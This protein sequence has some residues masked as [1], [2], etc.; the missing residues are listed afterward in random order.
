MHLLVLL[1]GIVDPKWPLP[2]EPA[3]AAALPRKLSPFD[4]SALE[5]ALKLRDADPS[6]RISATVVAPRV[7]ESVL[8]A[9]ASHRLDHVAGLEIAETLMWDARAFSALLAEIVAR[10]TGADLVLLGR[11]FGD[12]DDGV[13]APCLAEALQWPFVGL[14]QEVVRIEGGWELLRE[15]GELEERIRLPG[16]LLASVTN[17]R[18]NRLRHPLMKN[19]AAAKKQ[20]FEITPAD[21]ATSAVHLQMLRE[22]PAVRSGEPCRIIRGS[23]DEQAA[24]LVALLRGRS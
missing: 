18:R 6:V 11:E 17:D 8:R 1:S 5:C 3:A 10:E 16:P 22:R 14:A 20:V 23:I 19:V 24:E 7:E 12:G 13:L 4:E 9:V 15:R 2:A 21:A